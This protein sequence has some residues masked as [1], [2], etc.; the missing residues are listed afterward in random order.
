[1]ISQ[2][3]TSADD[4]VCEIASPWVTD[5]G[6]VVDYISD[7][8]DCKGCAKDNKHFML[9]SWENYISL[10]YVHE[11]KKLIIRPYSEAVQINYCPWCGRKLVDELVEFEECH[12]GCELELME[13]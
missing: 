5:E 10:G 2:R 3:T 12:C 11:I 7:C 1:M 13:D 6:E 8:S 4:N 9:S